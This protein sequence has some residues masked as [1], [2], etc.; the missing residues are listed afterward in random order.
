MQS[1]ISSAVCCL[2]ASLSFVLTSF[3]LSPSNRLIFSNAPVNTTD[4]F[5]M[6][7][8]YRYATLYSLDR[9]V[10]HNIRLTRALPKDVEEF[11]DLCI[12]HNTIELYL[13]LSLHFPKHFFESE[14]A[15][16][17]KK[18]AAQQIAAA[19]DYLQSVGT[20]T[21]GSR[22]NESRRNESRDESNSNYV[23]HSKYSNMLSRLVRSGNGTGNSYVVTSSATESS[24]SSESGESY[25]GVV[26]LPPLEYGN[27][28]REDTKRFLSQIPAKLRYVK[29]PDQSSEKSSSKKSFDE[30]SSN[31]YVHRSSKNQS[32]RKLRHRS[33]NS[34]DNSKDNSDDKNEKAS[35]IQLEQPC[36]LEVERMKEKNTADAIIAENASTAEP[37]ASE[38]MRQLTSNIL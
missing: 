38:S 14:S 5:G 25:G 12:K 6:N 21:Y 13:W 1:L 22:R 9:P 11:S 26:V 20:I 17:L 31:S 35:P 34:N 27:A 37:E 2:I 29:V 28:I 36:Q 4:S 23:L 30:S 24:S 10:H 32:Q 18:F 3:T 15:R 16:L 33:N 19:L 7:Q 8:L